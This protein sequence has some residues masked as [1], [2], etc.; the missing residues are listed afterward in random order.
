MLAVKHFVPIEIGCTYIEP[1]MTSGKKDEAY[2]SQNYIVKDFFSIISDPDRA[3]E[4]QQE[5][6][7]EISASYSPLM[8][9]YEEYRRIVKQTL[10]L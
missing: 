3:H 8:S 1:G 10:Y 7:N 6:L 9:S 2:K 5:A 4:A